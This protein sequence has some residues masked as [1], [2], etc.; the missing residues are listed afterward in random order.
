MPSRTPTKKKPQPATRRTPP[1]RRREPSLEEAFV[2]AYIGNGG[3]ATRAY[4][5]IHPDVARTTAAAEG[6]KL[7][8]NPQIRKAV[9]E[10]RAERLEALQMGADEAMALIAVSARAD[11]ADAYDEN[12]KVLPVQQWP[13]TLRLAVKSIRPGV[14]GKDIITLH[15]GLHARSLIAASH[16]KLKATLELKFD[17]AK[18]LGAT[19]PEE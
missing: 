1:P 18:Y 13:E 16:G 7:L 10:A 4:L 17:H 8:R 15:D 14:D 19:P 9:D 5:E 12:G 11:I 2:A 3:N 6:W